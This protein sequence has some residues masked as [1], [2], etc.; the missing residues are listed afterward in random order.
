MVLLM[1]SR[2]ILQLGKAL[3]VQ[4]EAEDDAGVP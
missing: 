4:L 3:V 2:S 1:R